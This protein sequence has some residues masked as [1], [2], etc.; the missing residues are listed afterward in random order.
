MQAP[1]QNP[2]NIGVPVNCHF[3]T[4]QDVLH[5]RLAPLRRHWI[6]RVPVAVAGRDLMPCHRD[7]VDAAGTLPS[8][9]Q[10][11]SARAA[12]RG[13]MRSST[14]AALVIAT[15][16]LLRR[17]SLSRPTPS[18]GVVLPRVGLLHQVR[19]SMTEARRDNAMTMPKSRRRLPIMSRPLPH[20]GTLIRS[21]TPQAR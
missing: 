9:A 2:T 8:P 18:T 12:K 15:A 5:D 7:P 3:Q 19:S 11:P 10:D 13:V 6:V 4:V 1:Q 17:L 20:P 16:A 14:T 21:G